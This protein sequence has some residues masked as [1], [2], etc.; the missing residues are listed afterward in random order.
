MSRRQKPKSSQP[1]TRKSSRLTCHDETKATQ[2]QPQRKGARQTSND[3]VPRPLKTLASSHS[4]EEKNITGK[5]YQA[6]RSRLNLAMTI[7]RFCLGLKRQARS[8]SQWDCGSYALNKRRQL[9]S[10]RTIDHDTGRYPVHA[11]LERLQKYHFISKSEC[12]LALQLTMAVHYYLSKPKRIAQLPK[13]RSWEIGRPESCILPFSCDQDE[14]TQRYARN[15]GQRHSDMTTSLLQEIQ[16]LTNIQEYYSDEARYYANAGWP[17]DK[18]KQVRAWNYISQAKA[19]AHTLL[20]IASALEDSSKVQQFHRWMSPDG[21][22]MELLLPSQQPQN[23][24]WLRQ[25][26]LFRLKPRA[27]KQCWQDIEKVNYQRRSTS[28]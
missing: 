17:L 22:Q 4:D 9:I 7:A 12:N 27:L 8:R 6:H 19:G 10:M 1:S 25:G 14:Y 3:R 28:C 16:Q 24:S 20:I 5:D 26:S 18:R 11:V 15:C 23:R 21:K 13:N 2:Q